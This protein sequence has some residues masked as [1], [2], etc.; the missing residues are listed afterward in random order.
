MDVEGAVA[1]R[2]RIV[3]IMGTRPEAIK[4]APVVRE[5]RRDSRLDVR[6]LATAQHRELLDQVLRHFDLVPD[7][8]L[9]LM[10]PGQTLP[11][12]TSRAVTALDSALRA[13]HPAMVIVQGDTTTAMTGAL[14]A[15]YLGIPVTHI[16]AG[17]R[18]GDIRNPFPEEVNRRIIS[19]LAA[20]HCAP[21]DGNRA[22]L[23]A[24]GVDPACIHVT[25]N[26][27]LDAVLAVAESGAGE[28]E[29]CRTVP[30][31]GDPERR[32]VLVTMHRRESFGRP[33]EQLCATIKRLASEVHDLVFLLPM[34]P[35]PSVR[36]TIQARLG[37]LAGVHL[38]EPLSYAP[39]VAAMRRATLIMS[40]SGGVQEEA[41]S[42]NTPVLV[43]RDATE[44]P[45]VVEVG[46]AKLVGRVPEAV[47]AA[48]SLLLT[49][50]KA[51]IAMTGKQNPYGDGRAS[52]RIRE[53][54]AAFLA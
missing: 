12:L 41:P 46:A 43:L 7:V 54:V 10:R 27:G 47:Y 14:S 16:E 21:T 29:L 18:S 31:L 8:D 52:L 25:G 11:E 24:E 44:R 53:A 23:V 42:L 19:Q 26:P 30:E 37:E 38:T 3:T 51:R 15:F 4:L 2:R 32:L 6:I 39:F 48:A 28:E 17:L 35:N 49:D 36:A 22:L 50:E 13:E 1:E 5:L 40:D 20:L 34:H 45:E 33:L 9:D